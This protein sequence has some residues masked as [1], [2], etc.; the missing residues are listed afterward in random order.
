MLLETWLSMA[1]CWRG[2][3]ANRNH[4]FGLLKP[5]RECVINIPTV[6]WAEQVVGRVDSNGPNQSVVYFRPVRSKVRFSV[7][8][9]RSTAMECPASCKRSEG[10]TPCFPAARSSN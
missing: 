10:I 8:S 2:V 9:Q 3:G 6:E 7:D 4:S 1:A 5:T